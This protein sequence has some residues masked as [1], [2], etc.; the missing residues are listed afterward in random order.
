MVEK[1]REE[2]AE[3]GR[4][5]ANDSDGPSYQGDDEQDIPECWKSNMLREKKKQYP[6]II[7]LSKKLGCLTCQKNKVVGPSAGGSQMHIAD[8]WSKVKV[9]AY[10]ANRAAELQS[11]HKKMHKHRMSDY[12]Q[13]AETTM[14]KAKEKT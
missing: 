12:H 11:L 2:E 9:T 1:R 3:A 7:C 8:E 14:E 6:W 5:S 4:D 13:A 10:G